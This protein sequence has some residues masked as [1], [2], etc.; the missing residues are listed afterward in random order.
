MTAVLQRS[1]LLQIQTPRPW[2][3][4]HG[5]PYQAA[6]LQLI[7]PSVLAREIEQLGFAI[8]DRREWDMGQALIARKIDGP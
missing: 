4:P 8:L 3:E 6:H 7:A 2:H 5:I 1:G